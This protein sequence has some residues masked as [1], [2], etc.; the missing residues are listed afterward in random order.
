MRCRT[1]ILLKNLLKNCVY[2]ELRTIDDIITSDEVFRSK[3]GIETIAWHSLHKESAVQ[4][5]DARDDA[6]K[7]FSWDHNKNYSI[8]EFNNSI[9]IFFS[10]NHVDDGEKN[11]FYIEHERPVFHVPEI[12]LY[13]L[14][15]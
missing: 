6:M 8:H 10:F 5:C 9:C 3:F 2:F 15:H 4:E 13:T 11:N 1:E 14:L 12:V 7:D